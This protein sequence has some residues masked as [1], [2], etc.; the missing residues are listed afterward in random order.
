MT[1]RAPTNA[2]PG[3]ALEALV[4]W[5]VRAARARA[6]T[7]GL[8]EGELVDAALHALLGA[9]R[10]H[11]A[12]EGAP[13]AAHVR[14]RV[15]GELLDAAKIER[16]RHD[17]EPLL[18]DLA[19]ALPA[20]VEE[21]EIALSRAAG[22]EA[23]VMGSP[24]TSLLAREARVAFEREVL[25]LQ[26]DERRFYELYFRRGLGKRRV[27]AELGISERTV[28]NRAA[29]IRARLTAALRAYTDDE[30]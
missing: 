25:L 13:L 10:T 18:D 28:V 20:G 29:A 11:D 4:T 21:D 12:A 14:R 27:A 17:R 30:G 6:A 15:R 26:P 5:A 24:E 19:Q 9:L 8:S 2:P 1:S 22:A 7:T 3:E 16:Q 23:L